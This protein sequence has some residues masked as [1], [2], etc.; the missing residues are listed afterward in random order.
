MPRLLDRALSLTL[1]DLV[2][3][4]R[5]LLLLVQLAQVLLLDL[6]PAEARR[7]GSSTKPQND[8]DEHVVLDDGR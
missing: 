1:G 5:C 7:E 2:T 8:G 6:G 4:P 3:T